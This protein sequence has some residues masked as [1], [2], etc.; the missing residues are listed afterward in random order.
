MNTLEFGSKTL[1]FYS[2]KKNERVDL[3]CLP[4]EVF[5]EVI[6]ALWQTKMCREGCTFTGKY[7]MEAEKA[8]PFVDWLTEKVAP[9]YRPVNKL[10]AILRRLSE[11]VAFRIVSDDAPTMNKQ[12]A[13]LK[14]QRLATGE[15]CCDT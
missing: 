15:G 10:I 9:T 4:D 1:L 8:K 2:L 6:H 11:G 14:T 5:D 3:S 13:I 7:V 12:L